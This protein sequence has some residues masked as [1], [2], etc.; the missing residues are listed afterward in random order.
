MTTV[1]WYREENPE[2]IYTFDARHVDQSESLQP[3]TGDAAMLV[4]PNQNVCFLLYCQHLIPKLQHS[5]FLVRIIIA[6][7]ILLLKVLSSEF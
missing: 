4:L 6:Y 7:Q 2:P 1:L 5:G 3:T